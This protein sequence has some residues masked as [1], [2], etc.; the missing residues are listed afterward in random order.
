MHLQYHE[1]YTTKRFILI[2]FSILNEQQTLTWTEI[3]Q[4]NIAKAWWWY[5]HMI[6]NSTSVNK[7]SV[8]S[9]VLCC[10][11]RMIHDVFD[12]RKLRFQRKIQFN[13]LKKIRKIRL[14]PSFLLNVQVGWCGHYGRL[15][16]RPCF[17]R[18]THQ[19]VLIFF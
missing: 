15:I 12:R 7:S 18:Q 5:H 16:F 1:I 17:P 2:M 9:R 8:F 10:P 4:T 6:N 11:I 3:V 14:N 19:N 13:Q